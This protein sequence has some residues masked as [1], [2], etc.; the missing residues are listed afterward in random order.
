MKEGRR[1]TK[2]EP[3]GLESVPQSAC[4]A[5]EQKHREGA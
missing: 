1:L 4:G 2:G 3:R 5:A